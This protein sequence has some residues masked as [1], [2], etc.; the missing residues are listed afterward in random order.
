MTFANQA[1]RDEDA[2]RLQITHAETRNHVNIS[3]STLTRVA[4]ISAF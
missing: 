4:L 1:A 2:T 3:A